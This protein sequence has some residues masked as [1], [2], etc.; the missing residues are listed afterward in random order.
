MINLF[1]LTCKNFGLFLVKVTL[2]PYLFFMI[3]LQ[4]GVLSTIHALTGCHTTSKVVTKKKVIS[5]RIKDAC[6]LLYYV[7]K[8]EINENMIANV[9]KCLLQCITSNI[10]YGFDE[11]SFNMHPKAYLKFDIEQFPPTP[12]CIKHHIFRAYSQCS[13]WYNSPFI[14]KIQM[15]PVKYG[16]KFDEEENL[17]PTVMT[18]PPIPVGFSILCNYSEFSQLGVCLCR[19]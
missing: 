8:N 9:E 4:N 13:M 19:R 5:E 17:V 11:L 10:V 7:Q 14:E 12:T 6:I 3:Y 15:N 2:E 16:Y 18:E 1:I